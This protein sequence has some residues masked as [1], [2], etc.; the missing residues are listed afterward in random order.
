MSARWLPAAYVG[1]A[2]GVIGTTA[3]I[4][5]SVC[6]GLLLSAVQAR[7]TQRLGTDTSLANANIVS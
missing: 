6:R 1:A 3:N 4:G 7:H 5:A 2:T